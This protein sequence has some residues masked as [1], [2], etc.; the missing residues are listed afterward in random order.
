VRVE[1]GAKPPDEEEA[2]CPPGFDEV[3]T[4]TFDTTTGNGIYADFYIV[5]N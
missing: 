1:V 2:G 3:R 4:F 5:F